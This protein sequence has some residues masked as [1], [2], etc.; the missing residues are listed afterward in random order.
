MIV[1][2]TKKIAGYTIKEHLG[3]VIGNTIR[4]DTLVRN[5]GNLSNNIGW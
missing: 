3:T 5:T 1:T 4:A 2:T